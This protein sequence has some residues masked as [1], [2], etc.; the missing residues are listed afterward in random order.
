G[1]MFCSQ[2][3]R[4]ALG[5]GGTATLPHSLTLPRIHPDDSCFS[6]AEVPTA[7]LPPAGQQTGRDLG[8]E[9]FATL[10]HGTMLHNPHCYCKTEAYP[11]RCQR[12]V[13]RRKNG[14]H[15]RTKSVK[16]L[17]KAHQKVRR[18][19]QEVHHKAALSLVRQYD[20]VYVED[21]RLRNMVKN[22]QL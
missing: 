10:S 6:C 1:S 22:P 7:P 15:R 9:S 8:L 18:Q 12:R 19:R 13:A 21:L 4:T 2:L 14:S 17:A 3:A 16:L 5:K 20:T 11:R